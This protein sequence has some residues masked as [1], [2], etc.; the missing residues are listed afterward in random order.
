MSLQYHSTVNIQ[1]LQIFCC[2]WCCVQESRQVPLN[3]ISSCALL[4]AG[5]DI[6]C[7]CSDA[8][9]VVVM[10]TAKLTDQFRGYD[11]NLVFF[12]VA[13]PPSSVCCTL[14]LPQSCPNWMATSGAF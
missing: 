1:L 13:V 14:L 12:T 10:R 2:R 3:V 5:A 4:R 11:E 6:D 8:A 7:C 9:A